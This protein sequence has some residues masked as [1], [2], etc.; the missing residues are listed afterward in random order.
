MKKT[1]LKSA[2]LAIAGVGLLAGSALALP[3]DGL[4]SDY[5]VSTGQDYWS[6]TDLTTN[7][8]GTSF[9]MITLEQAAYE[10]NFGLYTIDN[11]GAIDSRFE[12]FSKD[13]EPFST[14]TVTFWDDSG[15][16]KLTD[17][18]TNDGDNTNDG[19]V[20]FSSVFGFYYDVDAGN[21]GSIDYSF[22]TDSTLNTLDVGIEHITTA[23]NDNTKN[24]YIY[25]EDLPATTADWDW[26]D[27]TVL[28]NDVAPVPEPATMLLFGT[29]L[30][31][32][33]GV[34]RRKKARK[35]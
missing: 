11:T 19:W 6:P 14:N 13:T 23:Y 34:A 27:M 35:S 18:F 5:Q 12:V 29:G 1:F 10:S 15:S 24:V 3:W 26:T 21:N 22:Y 30:A 17:S 4:S 25:L 20:D 32:L 33:A 2:V 8:T 9:F 16:F 7:V 31:G 28:G